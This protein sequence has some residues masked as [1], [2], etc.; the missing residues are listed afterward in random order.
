[1]KDDRNGVVVGGDY[2]KE[3]EARDNVATTTDGGRTWNLVKGPLPGGFRSGVAYI[4]GAS[5]LVTVGPSG[6]D[7]SLDGGASW[8]P[9]GGAGYHAIS[10]AK[11]GAGW[12]VGENGRIAKYGGPS[13]V[14]R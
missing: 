8:T 14:R 9:I 10:F 12:A 7:Y 6:S 3:G 13:D 2:K 1:F 5:A 4:P 11:S